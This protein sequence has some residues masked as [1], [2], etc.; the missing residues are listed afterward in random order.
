MRLQ[1]TFRQIRT[2][3]CCS[4]S[5]VRDALRTLE[6]RGLIRREYGYRKNRYG[7]RQQTSNTYLVLPLPDYYENGEALYA[8][9]EELPL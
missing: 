9:G 1:S 7:I 5:S 4:D 3:C 6:D 8:Q 2:Q